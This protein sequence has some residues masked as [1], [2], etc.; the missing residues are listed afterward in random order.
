M[1][2]I[3][4]AYALGVSSA[5]G[6]IASAVLICLI[7]IKPIIKDSYDRGY[8]SGRAA[9]AHSQEGEIDADKTI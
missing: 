4:V 2:A 6:V 3:I 8:Q 1:G 7:I 5:L 9:N